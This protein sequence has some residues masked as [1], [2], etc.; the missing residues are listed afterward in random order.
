MKMIERRLG[1]ARSSVSL[2]VREIELSDRQ[3]AE[4]KLRGA[5]TGTKARSAY[6]HAMRRRYQEEGRELAKRG[7]PL[8]VAGCMLYWAE[9]SKHRNAMQMSNS[10]PAMIGFFAGFLRRYFNPPEAS[11]RVACNLFANHEERQLEIEDLWLSTVGLSR[12]CL[13]KS[14]VNTYSRASKRTRIGRLPYGTCRLTFHSTRAV[15]HIYGAI[16]EYG[17]F[18]V[19]SGWTD[20]AGNALASG[21]CIPPP[22][23]SASRPLSP[24]RS[25]GAHVADA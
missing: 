7:E 2:W 23:P 24:S 20:P 14:T 5:S 18:S 11:L 25:S 1:V 9:G 21:A 13:T 12:A 17:G 10:D 8:H 22:K 16:Q 3:R 19:R 4:I 15:Q 6:Y